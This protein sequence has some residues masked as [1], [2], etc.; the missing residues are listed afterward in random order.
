[1]RNAHDVAID[2]E[3][4]LRKEFGFENSRPRGTIFDADSIET[5]SFYDCMVLLLNKKAQSD[6]TDFMNSIYE[7][8]GENMNSIPDFEGVFETF[9]SFL[10]QD[11]N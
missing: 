7:F 2:L 6:C 5:Y 10:G 4:M 3:W 8:K 9:K 1:M 11:N